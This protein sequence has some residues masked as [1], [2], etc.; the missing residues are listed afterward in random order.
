MEVNVRAKKWSWE[1]SYPSG[2]SSTETTVIGS[3]SIPVF[4]LPAEK[5]VRVKLL[6][7]DVMHAFW[8]P[9]FRVKQDALPNRYMSVWFKANAPDGSKRLPVAA[10]GTA[11]KVKLA[12]SGAPYEDHW[13]FCAEYCGDMHSE[14][15]AIIRIVPDSVFK[16]WTDAAGEGSMPPVDLG[17]YLWKTQ[18]ATCHSVDGSKGTGPTWKDMYGH[19]AEMTTGQ[20]V[21]VCDDYIRESI[22]SPQ[23]RIVKGF[24]N[25][26]MP[27][28]AHFNND[29]INGLIAYMKTLSDKGG[30]GS[31]CETAK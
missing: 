6:S 22:M 30:A 20:K 1:M 28:F 4:Y 21:L 8:V 3:Q 10:P 26:N 31:P 25:G 27:S 24:E 17:Q 14:M 16:A 13:V 5:S 29:R 7:D 2:A 9:D 19:E 15:A 23:A 12:L 18:C 11:D